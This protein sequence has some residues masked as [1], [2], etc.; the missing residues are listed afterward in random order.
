MRYSLTALLLTIICCTTVAGANFY[1]MTDEKNAPNVELRIEY[2]RDRGLK[3]G[4]EQIT[5]E[6]TAWRKSG[7][8][9]IKLG[10]RRSAWWFR[11]TFENN[12]KVNST[13]F[14]EIAYP[15][16]EYLDF[17]RKT[18]KES[19]SVTRTG[20]A[21]PFSTRE[22][23][24]RHFVFPLDLAPG[25][26]TCYLRIFTTNPVNVDFN[27]YTPRSFMKKRSAELP[28]LWIYYGIMLVMILYNIFIFFGT[29]EEAYLYC[30][31]FISCV[32]GL[33]L[34]VN[35]LGF[36]HLWQRSIWWEQ[37]SA[38][39]FLS[40]G[41]IWLF[42]FIR[43]FL[44]TKK[45]NP[46]YD[47]VLIFTVIIPAFPLVALSLLVAGPASIIFKQ[48]V[49]AWSVYYSMLVLA[50]LVYK[51]TLGSKQAVFLLSGFFVLL[52][53]SITYVLKNLNF[54][55]VN[56]FTEWGWQIGS[57]MMIILFSLGLFHNFN[58]MKRA[59]EK[60]DEELSRKNL[61]LKAAN[62]ELQAANEELQASNE[63]FEAINEDLIESHRQIEE[64]E[65]KFRTML[66]H[67]PMPVLAIRERDIE[68]MN[69]IFRKTFGYS[70][71][72][73]PIM[74]K[75]IERLLPDPRQRDDFLNEYRVKTDSMRQ[76]EVIDFGT[77]KMSRP[78]G[79][80]I[81]IE[82]KVSLINNIHIAIFSDIT[83]KKMM[84]REREW[85]IGLIEATTDLVSMSSPDF[86]IIYMNRAGKTMLGLDDTD[87][88]TV[89]IEDC[90]P[91]WAF[92]TIKSEAIATAIEHGT[93]KGET[94]LKKKNG[95]EFPVSQVI[96]SHKS[97]E[98]EVEFLS[99]IIRDVSERKHTQ[100]L[101]IQTEK[102]MTVG[103]LAA[104]MAH[105]IN[106]PLGVILQAVQMIS[107]RLACNS[108][109]DIREAVK[110]NIDPSQVRDYVQNRGIVQ[111]LKG[112]REAGERAA[113]IVSN[114]LQFSRRA[115]S[116][117]KY[118]DIHSLIENAM[119]IAMN[120][121]DLKK[122]YDFRKI[123]INRD[124][125][126]D[127]PHVYCSA[128]EIEQV[129]LNLLKN[130]AQAMAETSEKSFVPAISIKTGTEG[131][132][133]VIEVSDNGPG[134]PEEALSHIFEPFYTTKQVGDG[135][136]LGLSVSYYI[137]TN[138]HKGSIS[139][140]SQKGKPTKFTIKVPIK[141]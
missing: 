84:E 127:L 30:S 45:E 55:P 37:H 6:K 132:N 4:I 91:S 23:I 141:E 64:N 109:A 47:K 129:I 5:T 94:A 105:E 78:D 54:L 3:A 68:Y 10:Y 69:L 51:I 123:I 126:P 34:A 42:L 59:L 102:M 90:Y 40:L 79:R 20:T 31:L 33:M 24:D 92:D 86:K 124:F 35:G 22:I 99:T 98:G 72:E 60:S 104:G 11:L 8:R 119:S 114:M 38:Y 80:A 16:F 88:A 108:D 115:E 13:V 138:N 75:V 95:E 122:R 140:V 74:G 134:I 49:Q 101:M 41:L 107:M 77:K 19:F 9:S 62:E 12:N 128:T 85:L 50:Y 131:N 1:T 65:I 21:R 46:V 56:F 26:N 83:E 52:I 121:Y 57:A 66:E 2:N 112:I 82:L 113:R 36:Q 81:Y 135:T 111:Y 27:C 25:K 29:R 133:A 100:E 96:M 106:N 118:E 14:F 70:H 17:Y 71:R 53:G 18:Q 87:I 89:N 44:E 110:L 32:I 7:S 136:G 117:A 76:G 48:A 15:R 28:A 93:W 67:F 103:G 63:E 61:A 73:A 137:I 130:A 58:L 120:D 116:I 97:K 139:V 125:D 39:F 43:S